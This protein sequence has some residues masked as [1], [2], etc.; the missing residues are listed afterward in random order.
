M[1]LA[2]AGKDDK[3]DLS[4]TQNTDLLSLLYESGSFRP[5]YFILA[6]SLDFDLVQ[7]VFAPNHL[8]IE[9]QALQNLY[10]GGFGLK[11]VEAFC[12]P[13]VL[14]LF[15][16]LLLDV[17]T[18]LHLHQLQDIHH[19]MSFSRNAGTAMSLVIR[20]LLALYALVDYVD[21]EMGQTI[22]ISRKVGRLFELINL[23]IPYRPTIPPQS[24]ASVAS[25]N[26]LELWHSRFGH[27]DLN[28]HFEMKDLGTLSYFLG[29]EVSTA[30][31][32]YYLS[33]AKY[34][35][36]LLSRA[37]L[38]DSKIA[39][40]PLEPNVSEIVQRLQLLKKK[41]ILDLITL[42]NTTHAMLDRALEYKEVFLRYKERDSSYKWLPEEDE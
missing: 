17:H 3:G 13:V 26:S 42:R 8:S 28:H 29:L 24:A 31:N 14:I 2:G 36:D 15:L 9:I 4:I 1:H 23:S 22:M 34:A 16:L 5:V 32:G 40:T 38:T 35:F 11:L 41:L 18:S 27:Q 20:L 10:L 39:S 30:S 21:P 6:G 19:L 7:P 12:R 25:Q 33:Q 37:S